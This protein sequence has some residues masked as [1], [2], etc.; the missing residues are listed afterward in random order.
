MT[1]YNAF[2]PIRTPS[3][4]TAAPPPTDLSGVLIFYLATDVRMESEIGSKVLEILCKTYDTMPN[5]RM[6]SGHSCS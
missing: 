3:T 2:H 4:Q 1:T 5:I 6:K